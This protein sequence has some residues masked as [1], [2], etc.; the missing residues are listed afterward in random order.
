MGGLGG[1][2]GK[3]LV[4]LPHAICFLTADGRDTCVLINRLDFPLVKLHPLAMWGE[5]S[6]DD[7]MTYKITTRITSTLTVP[8]LTATHLHLRSWNVEGL[9][10]VAKYDSIISYCRQLQVSLFCVQETKV[11][12]SHTFTTNDWVI[13]MSGLPTAKHHGVG[14]VCFPTT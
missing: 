9:R 10:E 4:S 14:F 13:L 8:L 12:S 11:D 3:Q 7:E 1:T 6:F 5:G 2:N